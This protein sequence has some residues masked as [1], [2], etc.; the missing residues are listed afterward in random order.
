MIKKLGEKFL[1]FKKKH[2]KQKKSREKFEN[3]HKKYEKEL[4]GKET[5]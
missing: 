5:E 4:V 3:T 2:Y 1:I